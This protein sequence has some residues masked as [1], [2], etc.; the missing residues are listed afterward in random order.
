LR[1]GASLGNLLLLSMLI[2]SSLQNDSFENKK[3]ARFD[4]SGKKIRNGYADGSHSEIEVSQIAAWGPD[5][6]RDRGLK[7]LRF[8]ESRWDFKFKNDDERER[9]LFLDLKS[10]TVMTSDNNEESSDTKDYKFS[11]NPYDEFVLTTIEGGGDKEEIANK[12]AAHFK[13]D[14]KKHRAKPENVLNN[15][16]MYVSWLKDLKTR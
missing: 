4:A 2:N 9:L 8:M 7:L 11:R 10:D 16:D 6:I 3:S 5:Q 1:Y 14:T 13:N 15:W 12:V